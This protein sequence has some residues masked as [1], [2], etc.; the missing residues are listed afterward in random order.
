MAEQGS[1]GLR[2]GRQVDLGWNV[3]SALI[4]YLPSSAL[5]SGTSG[6]T[7]RAEGIGSLLNKGDLAPQETLCIPLT[8]CQEFQDWGV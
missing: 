3:G 6:D 5:S 1:S 8:G 7:R 2:F 4:L